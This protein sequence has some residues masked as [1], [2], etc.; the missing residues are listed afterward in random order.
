M[1]GQNYEE[2][3]LLFC[4]RSAP[5][6]RETRE[7]LERYLT[8]KAAQWSRWAS[9]GCRVGY[10]VGGGVCGSRG[11]AAWVARCGGACQVGE[12]RAL[13]AAARWVAAQPQACAAGHA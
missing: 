2:A 10:G 9:G 1:I 6:R 8:A 5:L 12:A 4:I 3:C 13:A 11:D 7:V